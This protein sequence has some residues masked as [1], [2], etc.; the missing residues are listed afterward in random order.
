MCRL[1]C[2]FLVLTLYGRVSYSVEMG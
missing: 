2:P 1:T